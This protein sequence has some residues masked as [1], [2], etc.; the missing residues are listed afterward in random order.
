LYNLMSNQVVIHQIQILYC[1]RERWQS[2][3]R[4]SV[5]DGEFAFEQCLRPAE[6]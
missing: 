4:S 5:L 6:S 1:D 3:D 2:E